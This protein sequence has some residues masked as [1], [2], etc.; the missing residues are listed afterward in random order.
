MLVF[1]FPSYDDCDRDFEIR[2]GDDPEPEENPLC[3]ELNGVLPRQ[4]FR[5]C[6]AP[7]VVDITVQRMTNTA[8]YMY[9]CE[10]MAFSSKNESSTSSFSNS[11]RCAIR[12][13]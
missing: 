1:L 10:L 4:V 3:V 12:W 2:I 13:N 5:K 9:I 11:S 8:N 6:E 7:C